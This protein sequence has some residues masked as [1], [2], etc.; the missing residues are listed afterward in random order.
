MKF[1]KLLAVLTT[2][3]F[4][5]IFFND[6]AHAESDSEDG[7]Q[8]I[9]IYEDMDD[10]EKQEAM[11]TFV[12]NPEIEELIILDESLLEEPIDFLDEFDEEEV[13]F[14]PFAIINRYRVGNAKTGNDYT[15]TTK[16]ATTSGGP[17]VTLSISQTK[18]V[19]TTVNA[20]FGAS[21]KIISAEVGWSTTGS[22]S[23]NISGTFTVPARYNSKPV[24][25]VTFYARPVYKTKTFSV[26]KMAWN[27]T[28]WER[29]GMG[30]T[31]KAYGIAFYKTFTYK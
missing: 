9:T 4:F 12:S 23:I 27:S 3:F 25:R 20:K 17:G 2:V 29:Q 22:T 10:E 18:T 14:S 31:R 7:S 26:D 13:T 16:I 15:G 24:Q 5:S 21:D 19:S 6:V 1:N 8:T 11:D 30:T 28:K